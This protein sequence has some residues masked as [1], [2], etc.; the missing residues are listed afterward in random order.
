MSMYR[1][2]YIVETKDDKVVFTVTSR[3]AAKK[4]ALRL[5]TKRG[6]SHASVWSEYFGFMGGEILCEYYRIYE[7]EGGIKYYPPSAFRA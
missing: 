1:G 4:L 6:F 7:P 5:V 3:K 2:K